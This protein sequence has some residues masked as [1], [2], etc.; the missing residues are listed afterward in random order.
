RGGLRRPALAERGELARAAG[1]L[2]RVADDV[3]DELV[4]AREHAVD[5]RAGLGD[6]RSP[7]TA[8]RHALHRNARGP[9]PSVTA[10]AAD[11]PLGRMALHWSHTALTA[12]TSGCQPRTL[13]GGRG[14]GSPPRVDRAIGALSLAVSVTSPYTVCMA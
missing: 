6:H 12:R 1:D 9:A 13:A 8:S 5:E 3:G 7:P 10:T 14:A 11:V 4:H 2:V